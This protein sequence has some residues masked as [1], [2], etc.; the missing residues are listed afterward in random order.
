MGDYCGELFTEGGGYFVV[1]G[2]LFVVEG[3]WLVGGNALFLTG[4][5]GNEPEKTSGA[6]CALTGLYPSP[7]ILSI[8]FGYEFGYLLVKSL[9]YGVIGV[10]LSSLITLLDEAFG[11]FWEVIGWF[12]HTSSWDMVL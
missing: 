2:D 12:L 1:F 5:P 9:E 11:C 6:L 4:H 7:P 3:Y 8:I 10:L